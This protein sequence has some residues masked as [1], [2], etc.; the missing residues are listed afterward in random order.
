M[1]LI[2]LYTKKEL[3]AG[4]AVNVYQLPASIILRR[5]VFSKYGMSMN[6]HE[7]LM[8]AILQSLISIVSYDV[9]SFVQNVYAVS[10]LTV[11]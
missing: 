2:L 6:D 3:M 7:K 11:R 8:S 9:A 10:I 1:E 4:T 5:N